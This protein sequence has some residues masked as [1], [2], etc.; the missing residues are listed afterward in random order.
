MSNNS[1]DLHGLRGWRLLN[2]RQ[3]LRVAVMLQ[4]RVCGLSLQPIGCT[5]ALS[6]TFSAAAAA[7]CGMWRVAPLPFIAGDFH[8]FKRGSLFENRD[9][10]ISNAPIYAHRLLRI[11]A[12][13]S[14]YWRQRRG[15]PGRWREGL[16][17]RRKASCGTAADLGHRHRH[18]RY[19]PR[20]HRA[21][22][23]T[24]DISIIIVIITF[25]AMIHVNGVGY[26]D[27]ALSKRCNDTVSHE[28]LLWIRKRYTSKGIA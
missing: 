14:L 12:V 15:S 26:N 22:H 7:V 21:L 13:R 8:I 23:C 18:R 16:F 20:S 25:T 5:S 27:S 19:M 11:G 10:G 1:C 28:F 3:E 9:G 17:R 6:V 4:A 2:D 24:K